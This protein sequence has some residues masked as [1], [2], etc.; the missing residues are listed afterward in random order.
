MKYLRKRDGSEVAF[1][2]SKIYNAI[3]AANDAVAGKT[4][5]K[6]TII[7]LDYLTKKV[8]EQ[9]EGDVCTVEQVQDVVERML[10]KFDFEE[11]AKAYILYRAQRTKIREADSE[12]MDIFHELTKSDAID[13]DIKRENANIDGD[14]AMGT[15][16]KY[17]S[18]SAKYYV[19][20]YVLP[21]HIAKA[22]I[23][24]D[25]HIHD[26]DFYMLTET[27]CQ[28]DPLKLFKGGFSTGHGYLREPQSIGSYAALAA[29]AIQANQNEMHGGQ[30][31]A[32]FDY[33]MAP[34][35][36]KT[37]RKEFKKCLKY[38]FEDLLETITE[39]LSDIIDDIIGKVQTIKLNSAEFAANFYGKVNDADDDAV[40]RVVAKAY[41]RAYAATDKATYQ[42]ME[43]LVHNLNT[44]NSRAGAQ[45][46]Q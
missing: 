8:V 35:V 11:T 26:K 17:G 28:I 27:C 41:D 21:E 36:L 31:I 29:I 45:V 7:D 24:G 44:M 39:E 1:N 43:G 4:G 15:M 34:G 18:E 2:D 16:L 23:D 33:A 12:L 22:H 20:K 13:S 3:K 5:E 25:I 46:S 14:T 42:A 9:L 30:S 19:D 38:G 10:I 37:F 6:M 32:N 40:K